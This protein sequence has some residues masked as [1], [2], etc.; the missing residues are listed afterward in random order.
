VPN[1]VTPLN[2]TP[3]IKWYVFGVPPRTDAKK[4]SYVLEAHG[5]LWFVVCCFFKQ[6]EQ[7]SLLNRE[8]DVTIKAESSDAARWESNISDSRAANLQLKLQQCMSD[9]DTLQL[10]VEDANQA[11]GVVY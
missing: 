9:C 1:L 10:R 2:W 3:L 6:G 7:I 4:T 11:L 8:K 5:C